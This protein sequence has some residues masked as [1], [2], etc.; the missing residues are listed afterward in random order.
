ML[1]NAA[2]VRRFTRIARERMRIDDAAIGAITSESLHSIQGFVV[3]Q[4]GKP[5]LSARRFKD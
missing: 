1:A 4:G 3:A 2:I 5:G